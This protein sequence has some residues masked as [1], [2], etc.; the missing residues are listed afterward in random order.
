MHEHRLEF[1]G[2][3]PL[4]LHASIV[5]LLAGYAYLHASLT[6]TVLLLVRCTVPQNFQLQVS[7]VEFSPIQWAVAAVT[8]VLV[9]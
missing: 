4:Q 7:T 1:R 2:Q 6:L 3:P 9:P 8:V 5:Y